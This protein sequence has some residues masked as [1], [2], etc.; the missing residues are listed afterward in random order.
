MRE[1]TITLYQYDELSEEAQQQAVSWFLQDYPDYDWS[2]FIL[3]DAN[4]LAANLGLVIKPCT[5]QTIRG[6]TITEPGFYFDLDNHKLEY[7]GYYAYDIAWQ[8]RCKQTY[9]K[10]AFKPDTSLSKFLCQWKE[11]VLALQKSAFYG[12]TI[13]IEYHSYISIT[14]I[15]TYGREVTG[16]QMQQAEEL[17]KLF[18]DYVLAMLRQEYNWLIS[19][20]HA[21][22]MIRLNCY[23]F[24][25]D[26]QLA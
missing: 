8:G 21:E 5:R 6:E 14:V 18:N 25:E 16:K 11:K 4:E 13:D 12:L 15:N 22:E 1:K 24:T 9:G 3:T 23:E 17:L 10:D 2:E 7:K 20:E 26:G 19:I